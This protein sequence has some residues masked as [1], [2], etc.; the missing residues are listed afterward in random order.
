MMDGGLRK[1]GNE[2]V[3]FNSIVSNA[4]SGA[5]I[6]TSISTEKKNSSK[7]RITRR[8]V[9]LAAMGRSATVGSLRF[10]DPDIIL[11]HATMIAEKCDNG[12]DGRTLDEPM[13]PKPEYHFRKTRHRKLIEH[14]DSQEFRGTPIAPTN[15]IVINVPCSSATQLDMT[16]ELRRSVEHNAPCSLSAT[17][18]SQ[19]NA[20]TTVVRCTLSDAH[21]GIMLEDLQ[22]LTDAERYSF[23]Q[24]SN[25]CGG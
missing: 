15:S 3:N 13:G 17:D 23:S 20:N 16:A 12:L 10:S 4:L 1:I 7:S 2:V 9:S 19:A 5:P 8:S 14:P 6:R 22:S 24:I 25:S 18:Y 11:S 21:S